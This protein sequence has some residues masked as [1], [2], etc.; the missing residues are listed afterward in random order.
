MNKG[1]YVLL[2]AGLQPAYGKRQGMA[3][4][5]EVCD[6]TERWVQEAAMERR[7]AWQPLRWL[8][9]RREQSRGAKSRRGRKQGAVERGRQRR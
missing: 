7:G 8:G 1:N 3:V 6:G 5:Q 2:F 4:R 9:H